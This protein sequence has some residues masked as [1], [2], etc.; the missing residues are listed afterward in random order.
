MILQYVE[1][2]YKIDECEKKINV[3]DRYLYSYNNTKHTS[4]RQS[5]VII[6]CLIGLF[7]TISLYIVFV[8]LNDGGCVELSM[9]EDI[10][11][12]VINEFMQFNMYL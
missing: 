5:I 12:K 11:L 4:I 6:T 8:F 9:R 1:Q 3:V 7:F 2:H 10:I